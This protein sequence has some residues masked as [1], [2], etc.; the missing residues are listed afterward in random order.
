MSV[1][2]AL[3]ARTLPWIPR[4]IVWRVARRYIAGERLDDAARVIALLKARD[5]SATVDFLGEGVRRPE[6]ADGARQAYAAALERLHADNLPSGISVKLTQ[7]G[8]GIDPDLARANVESLAGLARKLGRFVR[9]DMED[10][11]TTD[12]TIA[13][14]R[15]LRA[16]FDNV[17]IVLQAYLRRTLDDAQAL[18]PLSPD[19][20]IC[21]GIYA[22]PAEL[23]YQ[24]REEVRESFLKLL[25]TLLRGG[26]RVAIATHDPYLVDQGLA[27]LREA[28]H[29]RHEFQMLLGVGHELRDRILSARARLRVY[30]PFGREWYPYSLRRLREN[31][32]IAGYVFRDLLRLPSRS[33]TLP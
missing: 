24:D 16:R 11:S 21:K 30:V 2:D 27:L 25:R 3:I 26:G 31:P 4:P 32:R 13:L 5:L 1:L 8:L 14:Y 10:S 17:G 33:H 28:E 20:R 12:A 19:I 29:G 23:A 15:H 7:L 6:D 9:I 18:L 22:E